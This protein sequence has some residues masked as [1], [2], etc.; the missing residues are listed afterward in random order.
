MLVSHDLAAIEATCSRGV[1]LHD[2]EVKT[3]GPV[4]EIL[5]EYRRS[6]EADAT[7]FQPVSGRISLTRVDLQGQ[8]SA[9][10]STDAQMEVNVELETTAPTLRG[11]ILGSARTASPIFVVNPGREIHMAPR[12]TTVRCTIPRLPIPRGKYSLWAGVWN[13]W[14]D[15]EELLA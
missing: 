8:D 6:V 10:L 5:S 12:R 4:S 15:G 2:G 1:W 7:R 13:K 9:M 11:S 14:T 3:T